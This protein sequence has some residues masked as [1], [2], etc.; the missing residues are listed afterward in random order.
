VAPGLLS[1]EAQAA[2]A[3]EAEARASTLG[4]EAAKRESAMPEKEDAARRMNFAAQQVMDL[5]KKSP[6][7]F[8]IFARPGLLSSVGGLINEGI[9]ARTSH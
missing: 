8:G 3:K 2:Q 7:A 6:N 9:R 1:Q 4:Q 5:T